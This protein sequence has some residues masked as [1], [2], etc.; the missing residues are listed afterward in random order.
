M[1]VKLGIT[2]LILGSCLMFGEFQ[3]TQGTAHAKVQDGTSAS[4]ST[5]TITASAACED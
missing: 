3:D 1:L 5:V 2:V 4:V